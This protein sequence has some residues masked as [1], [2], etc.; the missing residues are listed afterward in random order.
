MAPD[1]KLQA[2]YERLKAR[3]E[4]LTA[5]AL[6]RGEEYLP[7]LDAAKYRYGDR[8]WCGTLGYFVVRSIE[9]GLGEEIVVRTQGGGRLILKDG[10][11]S[12]H[13]R[14]NDVW[15]PIV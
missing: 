2:E 12:R 5:E 6:A 11:G 14:R 9:P 4:E 3:L 7:A 8:V 13:G 1:P 15:R 10:W